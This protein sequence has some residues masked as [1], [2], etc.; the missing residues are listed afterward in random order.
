MNARILLNRMI[1]VL[2]AAQQ[3]ADLEAVAPLPV[4]T[5]PLD[6]ALARA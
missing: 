5:L 3:G 1:A 2:E 4:G 6:E